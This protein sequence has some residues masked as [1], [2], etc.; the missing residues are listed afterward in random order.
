[1][2]SSVF[3]LLLGLGLL[4][5]Q[6]LVAQA[7][8]AG[9]VSFFS[10][11]GEGLSEG[12]VFAIDAASFAALLRDDLDPALTADAVEDLLGPDFRYGPIDRWVS[13]GGDA[14]CEM[15]H[16]GVHVALL[17]VSANDESDEIALRLA[18]TGGEDGGVWRSFGSMRVQNSDGV[19][20]VVSR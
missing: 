11:I 4:S 19:W 13:C 7:D 9:V 6:V 10:A 3:V 18:R 14:P 8:D 16:R 17:G 15:A 2:R 5:P 1:M 20:R 12:E